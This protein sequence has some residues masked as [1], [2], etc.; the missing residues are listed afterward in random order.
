[1]RQPE[2]EKIITILSGA[3]LALALGLALAERQP[4]PVE[5]V[6]EYVREHPILYTGE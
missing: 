3:I 5:L 6:Q 1:M 4:G 2:K